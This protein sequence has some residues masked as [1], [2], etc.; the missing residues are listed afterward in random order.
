MISRLSPVKERSGLF[1]FMNM[2]LKLKI[3]TEISVSYMNL[4]DDTLYLNFK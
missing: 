4:N 2:N 1:Q 3:P